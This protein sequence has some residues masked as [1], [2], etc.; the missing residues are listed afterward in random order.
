M[1][2]DTKSLIAL[3]NATI[4]MHGVSRTRFCYDAMGDSAFLTKLENGRQVRPETR[5]RVLAYI[6]RLNAGAAG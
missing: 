4:A 2:D 6:E 5:D 3:I 1:T